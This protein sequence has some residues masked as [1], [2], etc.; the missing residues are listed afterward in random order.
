M[1]EYSDKQVHAL[2]IYNSL[3]PQVEFEKSDYQPTKKTLT[4]KQVKAI[5]KKKLA[6]QSRKINRN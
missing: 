4:K 6:K 3:Y 2:E 5:A 1:K